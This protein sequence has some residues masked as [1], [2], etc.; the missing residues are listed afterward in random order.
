MR[1]AE[2][3]D[4]LAAHW[5]REGGSFGGEI[6]KPG[7]AKDAND[8][9]TG[10]GHPNRLLRARVVPRP[11]SARL[12]FLGFESPC[13]SSV[14]RLTVGVFRRRLVRFREKLQRLHMLVA[15]PQDRIVAAEEDGPAV[16]AL[17]LDVLQGLPDDLCVVAVD[18]SVSRHC[19]SL[20]WVSGA[21]SCLSSAV[22]VGAAT[23][24]PAFRGAP[25]HPQPSMIMPVI[26]RRSPIGAFAVR[27]PISQR[28]L[29]HLV[30]HWTNTQSNSPALSL[31]HNPDPARE[32]G[33]MR[34]VQ[35]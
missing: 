16:L 32:K 21:A 9:L 20:P 11:G 4:L 35:C 3:C 26:R 28:S 18:H 31:L 1:F 15:Y 14:S 8:L 6:R 12:S 27:W 29:P 2:L 19:W 25:A 7:P 33:Q 13:A 30:D 17:H 5:V 23:A 34:G 10:K 24:R 22:G